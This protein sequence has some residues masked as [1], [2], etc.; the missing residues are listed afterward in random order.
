MKHVCP[1]GLQHQKTTGFRPASGFSLLE[2]TVVVLILLV[3]GTISIPTMVTILSNKLAALEQYQQ[4][5]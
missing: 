3:V 2:L 4:L 5:S 1:L